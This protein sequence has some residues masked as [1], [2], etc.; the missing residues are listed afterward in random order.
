MAASSSALAAVGFRD[1]RLRGRQT[2]ERVRLA[3]PRR[4]IGGE[5]VGVEVEVLRGEEAARG[6]AL[7]EQPVRA[8]HLL[9]GGEPAERSRVRPGPGELDGRPVA[10]LQERPPLHLRVG[11]RREQRLRDGRDRVRTV[12]LADPD[13][14][15]DV[16]VGG[17]ERR[18]RLRVV[19]AEGV[20]EGALR[21]EGERGERGR[22]RRRRRG[23]SRR[24]HGRGRRGGRRRGERSGRRGVGARG[25]EGRDGESGAPRGHEPARDG[26]G[27]GAEHGATVAGFVGGR[28]AGVGRRGEGGGEA[29]ASPSTAGSTTLS[30][31][32]RSRDDAGDP[33]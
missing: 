33:A 4:E 16:G 31:L 2:V 26:R 8:D 11:E 27:E 12:R 6:E 9:R 7:D 3:P 23:R 14:E 19:R 24:E 32:T 28:R 25:G 21:R 10:G 22:R 1:R 5:R 30:T 18:E 15:V 17:V 29:F 20:E 13:P